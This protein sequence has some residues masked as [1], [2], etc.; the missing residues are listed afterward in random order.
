MIILYAASFY[1]L[2]G[3][4][5]GI[6]LATGRITRLDPDARDSGIGFR[7]LTLPG[8]VVFWPLLLSRD[9]R[10]I[11]TPPEERTSH[12]IVHADSAP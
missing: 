11:S 1:V 10:S 5:Y 12:K 9:V 8:V 3:L 2:V 4:L 7:L 6:V